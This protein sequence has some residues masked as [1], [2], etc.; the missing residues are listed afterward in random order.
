MNLKDVQTCFFAKFGTEQLPEKHRKI[1]YPPY[2]IHFLY[3]RNRYVYFSTHKRLFMKLYHWMV[4]YWQNSKTRRKFRSNIILIIHV[5]LHNCSIAHTQLFP[6][7]FLLTQIFN[8]NN[9]VIRTPNSTVMRSSDDDR[10]CDR[11][12]KKRRIFLS[13]LHSKVHYFC[14]R[15]SAL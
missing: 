15:G 5:R 11:I 3:S 12:I 6:T 2:I 13:V 4:V 10:P 8:S 9:I 7:P 14:T 1:T